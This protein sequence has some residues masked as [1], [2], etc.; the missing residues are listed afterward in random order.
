[1]LKVKTKL[2]MLD[3]VEDYMN[4]WFE[5]A[6]KKKYSFKNLQVLKISTAFGIKLLLVIT[7]DDCI[8]NDIS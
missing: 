6:D 7:Y 5:Q 1:M 2:I 3:Q 4:K 8:D